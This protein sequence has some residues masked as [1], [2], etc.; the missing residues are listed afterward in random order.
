MGL[1]GVSWEHWHLAFYWR[2]LLLREGGRR[3]VFVVIG[4]ERRHVRGEEKI[5]CCF[6]TPRSRETRSTTNGLWS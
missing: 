6:D 2:F 4:L 3:S 1:Y 5:L